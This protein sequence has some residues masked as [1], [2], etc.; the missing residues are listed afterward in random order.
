MWFFI[1]L[2]FGF[3]AGVGIVLLTKEYTPPG[4]VVTLEVTVSKD[5]IIS[6]EVLEDGKIPY[7]ITS[8]ENRNLRTQQIVVTVLEDEFRAL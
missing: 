8:V 5:G 6:K 4:H 1:G 2:I 7:T 3:A